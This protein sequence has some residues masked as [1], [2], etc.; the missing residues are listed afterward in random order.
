MSNLVTRGLGNAGVLVTAGLGPTDG[1]T[2]FES[3]SGTMNFLGALSAQYLPR[4]AAKST[5]SGVSIDI[6]IAVD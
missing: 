5:S 3:I 1:D 2:F 6:D 4:E